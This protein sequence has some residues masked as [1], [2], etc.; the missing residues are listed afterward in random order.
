MY[1]IY[2]SKIL[3]TISAHCACEIARENFVHS[4][5]CACPVHKCR[6]TIKHP[7]FLPRGEKKRNAAGQLNIRGFYHE[8]KKCAMPRDN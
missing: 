7:W 3:G 8:G 4:F 1:M 5:N 6:G 2:N